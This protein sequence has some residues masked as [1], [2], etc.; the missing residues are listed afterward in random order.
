MSIKVNG[1]INHSFFETRKC[2]KYAAVIKI[3]K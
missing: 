2:D 3:K 1:V